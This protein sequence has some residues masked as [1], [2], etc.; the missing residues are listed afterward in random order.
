MSAPTKATHPF[1]LL[2]AIV[3]AWLRPDEP[4]DVPRGLSDRPPADLAA[5]VRVAGHHM[6]MPALAAALEA[7]GQLAGL[8]ADFARILRAAR[9]YNRKRNAAYAAALEE[10]CLLLNGIGIE[11]VLLKGANRLVDDLY[12]DT[13]YR[14][15][16]D[17]DLLV[18]ADRAAE[19]HALLR[20]SG[21]RAPFPFAPPHHLPLLEHPLLPIAIELH[22]QP[23]PPPADRVLAAATMAGSAERRAFRSAQVR[24][25][26]PFE[27]IVHLIAAAQIQDSHR[28]SG[29]APLRELL[30]AALLVAR[31]GPDGVPLVIERFR[32]AGFGLSARLFF[33][34]LAATLGLGVASPPPA[35]LAPALI[36]H[37][38]RLQ[39]RS[40]VASA[41]GRMQRLFGRYALDLQWFARVPPYRARLIADLGTRSFY[42]RKITSVV[43]T[44]R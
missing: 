6:V 13:S 15:L 4:A 28:L 27:Q 41:I 5:L 31:L 20:G 37:W 38:A 7:Q 33:A 39:D 1:P 22:H 10:T 26:G 11:P 36:N 29:T 23:L 18:P 21:Y 30:E 25:P 3:R 35:G 12:P 8:P 14:F 19:A 17:L 44:W 2:C 34:R 40:A 24:L 42:R 9:H 43:R 16:N 32:Q